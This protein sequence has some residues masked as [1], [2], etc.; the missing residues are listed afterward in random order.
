MWPKIG[1]FHGCAALL[2]SSFCVLCACGLQR[3]LQYLVSNISRQ[4]G[5]AVCS[6]VLCRW[7]FIY[8]EARRERLS[9]QK[10]AV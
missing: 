1:C 10:R 4:D 8:R 5:R 6:R 2:P 7:R 9:R 3:D